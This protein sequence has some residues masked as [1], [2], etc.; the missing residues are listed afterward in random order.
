MCPRGGAREHARTPA[1]SG[2]GLGLGLGLVVLQPPRDGLRHAKGAPDG[3]PRD[4]RPVSWKPNA[5]GL[6]G[7]AEATPV[8]SGRR[9]PGQPPDPAPLPTPH[10]HPREGLGLR[11]PRSCEGGRGLKER[12]GK[13]PT[14]PGIPRRSPTQV[15][16]RPDPA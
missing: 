10:P 14:A 15:L 2:L 11:G 9:G 1:R 8:C 13:K 3:D 6:A 12:G 4:G 16:T 5:E 7:R